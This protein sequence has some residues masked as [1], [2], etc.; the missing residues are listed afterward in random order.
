MTTTTSDNSKRAAR[1]DVEKLAVE[2]G[3]RLQALRMRNTPSLRALRRAYS[4][5]IAK[6]P[7]A[8]VLELAFRV[9]DPR[10]IERRFLAYELVCH[11]RGA[12]QALR[13]SELERLGKGFNSWGAVDMFACLLAGPAWRERQVPDAWL[14]RWA[15][16]PDR[17]RR[18]GALVC[19][20]AL[21]NKARGG[22][23]DTPRTLAICRQLAG[24]HDD[25]VAKAL[26]WALRELA[27]RD[28]RAAELFLKQ[29]RNVLAARVV[30][31]VNNK[32]TT[33]LKNPRNQR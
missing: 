11:H 25:I 1:I 23:G 2:I 5:L 7:A 24:D 14:H 26:S 13:S 33:G 19:T 15:R 28:P 22:K 21:N 18:R 4:R 31:E 6:A 16:S 20:V 30:R 3:A 27:K 10:T 8:P 29:Y 32:L 12:M 9:F 17:W